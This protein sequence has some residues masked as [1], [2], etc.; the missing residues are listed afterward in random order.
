ME[1]RI[2]SLD[3][4]INESELNEA[5][6]TVEV[7]DEDD[8]ISR[9]VSYQKYG[10]KVIGVFNPKTANRL[11]D[12]SLLRYTGGPSLLDG[13]KIKDGEF[14]ARFTT[15]NHDIAGS[16]PLIKVNYKK[17]L[18]YFLSDDAEAED[19]V[20]FETKGVPVTYMKLRQGFME[21]KTYKYKK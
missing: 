15:P 20:E 18:V 9:N 19:T 4:F 16:E 10:D 14:I 6:K 17:G 13:V 7:Q 21:D 12:Y 5:T 3:E 1:K 8:F 11:N 2:P